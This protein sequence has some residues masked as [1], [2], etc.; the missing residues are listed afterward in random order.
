M[1]VH[2]DAD[3]IARLLRMLYRE[4]NSYC[5]HVDKKASRDFHAAIVKVAQ[6]F[7]ENV[8]VI[9]L[10][11]RV[12]VTWAYYSLLK[13]VLMCAEKLLLVNTNWR[14]LINLSG[15]EMPLRTNWEFV[16]LLK[17]LNG[18]NM[19]EY[20]D[21]DKFP[22]RSPKKTLSHKVSFIREKNIPF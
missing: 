5:I 10:G 17:A 8:H 9:P 13:A 6:C 1:S 14:Y 2:R 15:Q 20:D 18:S 21:F 16:T 11:K 7:G 22:E 12:R 3:Q 19:V 4:Q